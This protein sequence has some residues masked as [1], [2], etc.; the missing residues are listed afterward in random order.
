MKMPAFFEPV[1]ALLM[2]V[3]FLVKNPAVVPVIRLNDSTWRARHR[4]LLE[5]SRTSRID[6]LFMGDSIT[7]GWSGEGL[8]IWNRF[9][10]PRQAAN[11]GMGGDRTQHVL[12]RIENGALDGLSPKVIVLLIGTNNTR[13]NS[14]EHIAEGVGKI[15]A[16]MRRRCPRSKILL[17]AIFPRNKPSDRPGKLARLRLANELMARLGDGKMIRFLNLN[18]HFLGEDGKVP[19]D[20]M[21]DFLHLNQ[22]GYQIWADA[23]EPTLSEMLK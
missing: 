4:R 18:N 5:Q 16:E 12:W 13:W 20:I 2:V 6:L 3:P 15:V 17:L 22:K 21:P 11:F 14:G 19:S 23:M 10:A 7:S 8:R 1:R 9:Y